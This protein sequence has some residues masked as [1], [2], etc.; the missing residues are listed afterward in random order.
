MEDVI[1]ENIKDN[2]QQRKQKRNK[3]FITHSDNRHEGINVSPTTYMRSSTKLPTGTRLVNA[4]KTPQNR[5]SIPTHCSLLNSN[6]ARV[7]T[8]M[9]G[10][11]QG[12]E[13]YNTSKAKIKEKLTRFDCGK[14]F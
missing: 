5:Y 2:V 4:L 6:Y 10:T 11:Q 8:L 7:S 14:Q 1:S 12:G 9:V 13:N 3:Y